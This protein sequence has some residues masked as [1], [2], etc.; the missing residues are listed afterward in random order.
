MRNQPTT[1]IL[2]VDDEPAIRKTLEKRLVSWNNRV[3]TAE[4]GLQAMAQLQSEKPDIVITDL[5][6][7][8]MNG[9]DL[10]EHITKT[11][12]H[13]PVIVI[14]GQGELGDVIRALRLGAWDYIY[15]PIREMAF[16]QL[17]IDRVVEKAGIMEE[18]R[19]YRDHLEALVEQKSAELMESE[20]RYRTVA[21]FAYDWE[22]WIDPE[23]KIVYMS[24]SCERVTGYSP[25][26]FIDDPLLM[27]KIIL[28]DDLEIYSRHA[29]G[30]GRADEIYQIEFRIL[31]RDGQVVWIGHSCRQVR[32]S[33]GS[34][35]GRR[36]SNRDITYQKEI[37]TNLI[38]QQQELLNK[39]ISQEKAN[40]ALKAL[41]GQREIEKNAIEQTM[42]ANLK[43]FVYPYLD[44][45][46]RQK[47]MKDARAY[48]SIIRTHIDQLISPVSKKL[49][50]A[51][52]ELTPTEI[53]VADLIRQGKSTKSIAGKLNISP[54]T[55][56]KHRNK[57][58]KKLNL[59]N[60]NINLRTYL[61]TL[62]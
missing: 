3:M 33:S 25:Q 11:A 32:D 24:P 59:L 39:T 52:L 10:L 8:G 17:T 36:C 28:K 20:K 4:N 37:E 51:Y 57:I 40:A 5:F 44:D 41:L 6:M 48:V 15:K 31:R 22:Y 30:S 29:D 49:S 53:K 47:T 38:R 46:E 12:P 19:A 26:E 35:L 34:Y 1:S 14:S 62:T 45:L 55:V 13:T 58:R 7:P 18:N 43:R 23:K 60:K 21:D 27:Q 54:S 61:N 2:V 9:F 16:L 42:V 56:E 50:G